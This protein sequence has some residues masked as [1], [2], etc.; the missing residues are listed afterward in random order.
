[1]APA[2]ASPSSRTTITDPLGHGSELDEVLYLAGHAD[3][4]TTALHGRRK[5]VATA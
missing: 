5:K 3:S 2:P 1:M 4:R